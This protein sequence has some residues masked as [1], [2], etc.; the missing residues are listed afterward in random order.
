MNFPSTEFEDAVA[1]VCQGTECEA[2]V[3]ELH[4]TLRAGEAARDD[5]LW[6]VELHAYLTSRVVRPTTRPA[7][8][9]NERLRLPLVHRLTSVKWLL[10]AAVVLIAFIGGLSWPRSNAPKPDKNIVANGPRLLVQFDDKSGVMHEAEVRA[11]DTKGNAGTTETAGESAGRFG[12]G[13]IAENLRFAVAADAPIIVGNG[14]Q[15]PIELGAE[16]PYANAGAT[17]HVW[18]WSESQQSRV[19]KNIPLCPDDVF[20]LSPDGTSLVWAKG[21]IL[22]LTNGERSTIDLGGETHVAHRGGTLRRIEHLQFTPDGRRLA[23][24]LSNLVLTKSSHPLRR[25]DLTTSQ[26]FQIVEFPAGTLV[27]EFPADNTADL[28]LAFSADLPLAFSADGTRAVSQY[29]Q[30]KSGSQIVE[31]SALTGDVRRE[32]Q[33]RLGEFARAIGLSADGTLLAV[34]D[35]AGHALLWD[36]LTGKLKHK[37]RLPVDKSLSRLRFSPDGKLLALTLFSG[38]SPKLIV[39]DVL[40]GAVAATESDAAG[41]SGYIHWSADSQSF[42]LICDKRGLHVEEDKAGAEVLY[43]QYPTVRTWKVADILSGRSK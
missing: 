24:L 38:V 6:Q 29:L 30:G 15:E 23:L 13:F 9:V 36:T 12:E 28:P 39:I 10:A 43:N 2:D 40:A 35:S 31:R 11:I 37:V 21:D 3:A 27:C 5:Y 20:C 4:G 42:E 18:D 22:N 26:T 19:M 16:V 7:L 14:G 17:L 25:Q 32:Y 1:A 33:P 41:E 8:V 34:Y